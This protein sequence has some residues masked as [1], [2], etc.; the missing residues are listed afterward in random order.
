MKAAMSALMLASANLIAAQE[1]ALATGPVIDTHCDEQVEIEGCAIE[2]VVYEYPPATAV[3]SH[4]GNLD[5][6]E[7][8]WYM[9]G[10][11]MQLCCTESARTGMTDGCAAF[12]YG[13]EEPVACDS[14]YEASC[15]GVDTSVVSTWYIE[16]TAMDFSENTATPET[17]T[18]VV[19][20]TTEPTCPTPE[21]KWNAS[22]VE[23]SFTLSGAVSDYGAAEKKALKNIIATGA[24]VEPWRVAIAIVSGSVVVTATISV[25][26]DAAATTASDALT[27]GIMASQSAL[28]AA[29]TADSTLATKTAESAPQTMI[30]SS[31]DNTGIIVVIVVFAVV[32]LAI[33][34]GA[35]AYAKKTNKSMAKSA[36]KTSVAKASSSA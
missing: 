21:G 3:D 17:V 1:I 10:T 24:G 9:D 34:L 22:K 5:L 8:V 4:N 12:G 16:Y 31:E 32:A 6:C 25:A 23:V 13:A 20:D 15:A 2:E 19:T 26:S 18:V 35:I 30:V 14:S 11:D 7:R 33:T 29:I 28:Q 36:S 27:G